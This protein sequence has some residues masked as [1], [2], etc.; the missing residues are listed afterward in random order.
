[1]ETLRKDKPTIQTIADALG[2]TG[3]TV[4]MA[5]RGVARISAATRERVRAEAQ[6]QGYA[7]NPL[8]AAWMKQVRSGRKSGDALRVAYVSGYPETAYK[9]PSVLFLLREGVRSRLREL[10]FAQLDYCGAGKE[11]DWE[12]IGNDLLQNG[13]TSVILGPVLDYSAEV[14]LPWE[15]IS[16]VAIGHSARRPMLHTVFAEQ[17]AGATAAFAYLTGKGF[18]RLGFVNNRTHEIRFSRGWISAFLAWQEGIPRRR[19]IPLLRLERDKQ[20]DGPRLLAWLRRHQPDLCLGPMEME[21]RVQAAARD[22]RLSV[23]FFP[24][25][26]CLS[27]TGAADPCGLVERNYQVGVAAA[28]LL[29]GMVYRH[30]V[31]L[32][33][34]PVE[35]EIPTFVHTG[36]LHAGESR[37]SPTEIQGAGAARADGFSSTSLSAKSKPKSAAVTLRDLARAAHVCPATVSRALR[38]NPRVHPKTLERV[39]RA[40]RATGYQHNPLV[41]AWAGRFGRTHRHEGLVIAHASDHSESEYAADSELKAL[42]TSMRE[43]AGEMGASVDVFQVGDAGLSGKRLHAILAARGIAEVLWGP[44]RPDAS[45]LVLPWDGRAVVGIETTPATRRM[46]RVIYSRFLS[47]RTL[48]VALC[49]AGYSR[50]GLAGFGPAGA[51]AIFGWVPAFLQYAS[52]LRAP[53]RIPW[54]PLETWDAAGFQPW[55]ERYQPDVVLSPFP[56]ASRWLRCHAPTTAFVALEIP[57]PVVEAERLAAIVPPFRAIGRTALDLLIA[58]CDYNERGLP[59]LPRYTAH[60]GEIR[61]GPSCPGL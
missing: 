34:V 5:L 1:M 61:S 58:H 46:H 32:P 21:H 56:E 9:Q 13:I 35:I 23:P 10:G 39:R 53:Q 18:R 25:N 11:A 48:L 52:T 26:M 37:L 4:S 33:R 30:E 16:A 54:L 49:E 50:P 60:W 51:P 8:V 28:D 59:A 57:A 19:R 36:R 31:G 3:A 6:R 42:R 14:R 22:V 15:G 27:K 17:L 20:T 45:E 44:F 2:L 29:A 43:R 12:N 55:A 7:H 47:M 41:D 24:M 38:N 40:V